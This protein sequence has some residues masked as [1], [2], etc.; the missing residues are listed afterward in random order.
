MCALQHQ[1]DPVLVGHLGAVDL[2]F[3]DQ[4]FCIHQQMT[5]PAANLLPALVAPRFATY[6]GRLG[7]LR[8]DHSRA[9]LGVSPQP[10][11]QALAQRRVEPLPHTVEAPNPEVVMDGL[12]GREVVGQKSPGTATTDDVEDSVEDLA[13]RVHPRSPGGF[14]DGEM[15]FYTSPFGVGEVGVV[16]LFH[17]W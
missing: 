14:W 7:R 4:S 16:C 9:G 10:H 3:E 5:L 15:R 2:G 11:P 1:L 13:E 12:P 6:P 8:I 17:A